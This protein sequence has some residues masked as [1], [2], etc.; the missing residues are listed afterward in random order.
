MSKRKNQNN[1]YKSRNY[2]R[3]KV[4][5]NTIT[6]KPNSDNN[7]PEINYYNLKQEQKEN[8]LGNSEVKKEVYKYFELSWMKKFELNQEEKELLNEILFV[9]YS[10]T[11]FDYEYDQRNTLKVCDI[12]GI[13]IVKECTNNFKIE[14]NTLIKLLTY[15]FITHRIFI[16]DNI[17]SGGVLRNK[18]ISSPSFLP[19]ISDCAKFLDGLDDI[20][21][22]LNTRAIYLSS[23]TEQ[24]ISKIIAY[25]THKV[26][27]DINSAF[28]ETENLKGQIITIVGLLVS[29][30][31]LLTTNL[32]LLNTGGVNL[33]NILLT[34]GILIL[35]IGFIFSMINRLVYKDLKYKLYF[36][37]GTILIISSI[38]FNKQDLVSEFWNSLI[39]MIQNISE[40]YRI[41]NHA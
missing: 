13:N 24:N 23:S 41:Q 38:I 34:N 31:P 36:I 37:I 22:N 33:N 9:I 21:N 10:N 17:I 5:N 15:L 20:F 40:Y 12:N 18:L 8:I 2:S 19:D 4:D 14:K 35:V 7:I 6:D 16:S 26:S 1:K 27:I 32:T 28:K 3:K 25:K 30:V 39:E 29:I 11:S